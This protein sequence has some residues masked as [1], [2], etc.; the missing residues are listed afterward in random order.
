MPDKKGGE[1]GIVSW[2]LL[3]TK[4]YLVVY[5]SFFFMESLF[6]LVYEKEDLHQDY[7]HLGIVVYK[8]K[9]VPSV[10]T[11]LHKCS[12]HEG[13]DAV[14]KGTICQ[15]VKLV[16]EGEMVMEG[17]FYKS[18]CIFPFRFFYHRKENKL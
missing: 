3:L 7:D 14:Y 5:V 6:G 9:N 10:L 18:V 2:F 8:E 4:M 16:G 1:N 17:D 15:C 13:T 12:R 11:C